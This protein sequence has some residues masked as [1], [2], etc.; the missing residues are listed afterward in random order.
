MNAPI[1]L[2]SLGEGGPAYTREQVIQL[3]QMADLS[4]DEIEKPRAFITKE[5]THERHIHR[6]DGRTVRVLKTQD[7]KFGILIES[8]HGETFGRFANLNTGVEI[9]PDEPVFLLRAQDLCAPAGIDGYVR[10]VQDRATAIQPHTVDSAAAALERFHR[11]QEAFPGRC[12][13]PS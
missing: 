10:A 8:A 9:P 13:L 1:K 11:F 3:A 4:A 12:K 6:V 7:D 2:F 5:L